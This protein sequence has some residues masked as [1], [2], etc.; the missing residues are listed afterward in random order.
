DAT[1]AWLLTDHLGSVRGVANNSGVLKD[2]IAYD[3]WGNIT[4]ELDATWGGRLKWTGRETDTETNLQYNRA[5]YY[6]FTIGG[7]INRDPLGFGAGDTNLY[8]Y[9]HNTQTEETDPSGLQGPD[10][11][12]PFTWTRNEWRAFG[13]SIVESWNSIS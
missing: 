8:R 10:W 11:Y 1:A 3:G 5:R 7:W 12:N 13:G 6:S 4:S 9:V 2:V